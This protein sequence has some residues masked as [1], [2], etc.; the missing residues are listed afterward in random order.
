[1]FEMQTDDHWRKTLQHTVVAF[2]SSIK[3][4]NLDYAQHMW[5]KLKELKSHR[6]AEKYQNLL[7]ENNAFANLVI[8]IETILKKPAFQC[9]DERLSPGN[10]IIRV[11]TEEEKD[12]FVGSIYWKLCQL[13]ETAKKRVLTQDLKNPYIIVIK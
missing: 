3:H 2:Y 6:N 10:L 8:D 12:H 4:G 11:P 9:Y 13:N 5:N 7:Y 1:M